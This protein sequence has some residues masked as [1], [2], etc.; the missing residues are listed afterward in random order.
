MS[1]KK[2]AT[3]YHADLA[4]AIKP[5][6]GQEM[7]KR[8]IDKLVAKELPDQKEN[9]WIFPSDHC[10]NRINKGSCSCGGSK[11]A[12]FERVG[13]GRYRVR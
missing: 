4:R 6:A 2:V 5:F 9:Q 8:E 7:R 11:N 12:L 10:F 3:K 1:W 13:W